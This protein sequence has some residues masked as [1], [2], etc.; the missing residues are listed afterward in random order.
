VKTVWRCHR[1]LNL[2]H[3]GHALAPLSYATSWTRIQ[4]LSVRALKSHITRD[5]VQRIS[6]HS[7]TH[8][9]LPPLQRFPFNQVL[10]WTRRAVRHLKAPDQTNLHNIKPTNM[11]WPSSISRDLGTTVPRARLPALC[12]S[13]G[14][15]FSALEI[16]APLHE[17]ILPITTTLSHATCVLGLVEEVCQIP[18]VVKLRS[19]ARLLPHVKRISRILTLAEAAGMVVSIVAGRK[20]LNRT[21]V[22]IAGW[23]ASDTTVTNGLLERS[24]TGNVTTHDPTTLPLTSA[25]GNILSCRQVTSTGQDRSQLRCVGRGYMNY[26]RLHTMGGTFSASSNRSHLSF[27]FT[28]SLLWRFGYARASLA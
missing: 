16:V 21:S 11:G 6:S 15:R 8:L 5:C 19:V 23:V 20:L 22:N 2:I 24:I 17:L 25:S 13:L 4:W 18:A 9:L 12:S 1:V 28:R 7:Q 14:L 10:K 26:T 3:S 27:T